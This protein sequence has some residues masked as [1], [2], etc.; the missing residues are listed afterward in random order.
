MSTN[1]QNKSVKQAANELRSGTK[2]VGSQA[3]SRNLQMIL[4]KPSDSFVTTAHSNL[5]KVLVKG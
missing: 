1:V 3:N 2:N 4:G 5:T